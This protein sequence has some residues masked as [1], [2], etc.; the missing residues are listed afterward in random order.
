VENDL[1]S[2]NR[3]PSEERAGIRAR[4]REIIAALEKQPVV[5]VGGVV[6]AYGVQGTDLGVAGY[7]EVDVT[8][9]EWKPAGGVLSDSPLVLHKNVSQRE[10]KEAYLLFEP[11]GAVRVRAKLGKFGDEQH[12]ALVDFLGPEKADA[13]MLASAARIRGPEILEDEFFG[14]FTRHAHVRYY[15]TQSPWNSREVRLEL[16]TGRGRLDL[17]PLTAAAR[18]L[19]E[20]LSDWD[21]RIFEC[22]AKDQPELRESAYLPADIPPSSVDEIRKSLTLKL[23]TICILQGVPWVK[24]G[25]ESADLF[26]G[27]F[28]WVSGKVSEGPAHACLVNPDP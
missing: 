17:P 22:I 14:Q 1:E 16:D 27:H 9:E 13:E 8:F 2:Q 20:R 24:F 15:Y 26:D 11:F 7:C 5:E 18:M 3:P 28:I 23:V 6:R 10:M 19:W 21:R 4:R 25:F 12:A